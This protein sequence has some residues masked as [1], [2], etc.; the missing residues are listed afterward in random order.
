MQRELTTKQ[1]QFLAYLE[2]FVARNGQAPSLRR[3]AAD[4][5][6][7][8]GAVSQM[9]RM[10]EQKGV[11]R[12]EGRYSRTI[13]LLNRVGETAGGMHPVAVPVIGRIAAGL[14]LYAQQEWDGS[15]VIDGSVYT[16]NNLFALRVRG[17]SMTDAAILDG[18]LV[19]C[20]PSQYAE[21]GDIVVALVDQE[22][23][24]VKRFFRRRDH[25]ELRPEN[26]A[27]PPMRYGFNQVL[28]QGQVVGVI[29]GPENIH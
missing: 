16:G 24:T 3:A 15:I 7:S 6:V 18:D 10:L 19:I 5:D 26:A 8:H 11:V 9:I 13:H 29:R 27:Y 20:E 25:I 4:M 28:V 14:P 22:E 21:N 17:D 1:R 2:R 23:A 12:R